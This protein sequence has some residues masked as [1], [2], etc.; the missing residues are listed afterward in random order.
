H[1][2]S[3]KR[4][5]QTIHDIK[6]ALLEVA[7]VYNAEATSGVGS[8]P[9]FLNIE[10]YLTVAPLKEATMTPRGTSKLFTT[11]SP[12]SAVKLKPDLPLPSQPEV[13]KPVSQSASSSMG[14]RS[15][16]SPCHQD[17]L[18]SANEPLQVASKPAPKRKP[19]SLV[20]FAPTNNGLNDQ[21]I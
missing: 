4:H 8:N 15:L 16:P 13:L 6:E 2:I 12:A 11:L 19:L 21:I 10:D 9:Q 7:D 17:H 5:L 18:L 14:Q 1:L 3:V 20:T